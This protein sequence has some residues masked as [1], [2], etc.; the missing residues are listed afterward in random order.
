MGARWKTFTFAV[1]THAHTD[2]PTED[3]LKLPP[4]P[5]SS[6]DACTVSTFPWAYSRHGYNILCCFFWEVGSVAAADLWPPSARAHIRSPVPPSVIN[7]LLQPGLTSKPTFPRP[8]T[9]PL[10]PPCAPPPAPKVDWSTG[11]LFL[12]HSSSLSF[13]LPLPPPLSLSEVE[14]IKDCWASRQGLPAKQPR[15]YPLPTSTPLTALHLCRNGLLPAQAAHTRPTRLLTGGS[16]P[17][18]AA[19]TVNNKLSTGLKCARR[20]MWPMEQRSAVLEAVLTGGS[21]RGRVSGQ[22]RLCRCPRGG[23]T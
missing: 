3:S 14:S 10:L 2:K 19:H 4:T 21:I 6:V 9:P 11:N 18:L 20:L 13:F 17:V 12:F 16:Q 7:A 22:S 1:H 5:C 15:P 23:L 8:P